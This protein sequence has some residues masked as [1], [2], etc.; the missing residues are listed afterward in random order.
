MLAQCESCAAA[1]PY[2][3]N[4]EGPIFFGTNFVVLDFLG[5]GLCRA[6]G[7]Y[8]S[9]VRISAAALCF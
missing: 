5:R 9:S 3:R 8:T 4:S 6:L 1:N 7:D 2:A